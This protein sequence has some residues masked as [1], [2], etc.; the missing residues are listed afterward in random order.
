ME[1]DKL[2]EEF[3]KKF[4]QLNEADKRYVLAISEALLFAESQHEDK[5]SEKESD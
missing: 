3:V 1:E 2:I 5:G 4:Q